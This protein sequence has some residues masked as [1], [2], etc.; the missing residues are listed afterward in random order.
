M[1]SRKRHLLT[2]ADFN[3][4]LKLFC[5]ACLCNCDTSNVVSLQGVTALTLAVMHSPPAVVNLLL[6]HGA[7]AVGKAGV[8]TAGLAGQSR[9]V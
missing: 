3:G 5:N 7:D 4:P 9:P 1:E 2:H 8:K 6:L